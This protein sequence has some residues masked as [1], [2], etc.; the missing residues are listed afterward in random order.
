MT[1]AILEDGK[2]RSVMVLNAYHLMAL[3]QPD[4]EELQPH[5]KQMIYT[6]AHECGHVHDLATKV[7]S[8]PETGLK[9]QL[10]RR[11]GAL[12][13]VAEACWSGYVASR[14]SS[15]LSPRELT[16]DYE[17][18]FCEQA[19]KGLPAVREIPVQ[20]VAFSAVCS[21]EFQSVA[22]RCLNGMEGVIGSIPIR[23]PINPTT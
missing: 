21:V 17:N 6:L 5:Y 23:P 2:A 20:S 14:L 12:F 3:T 11:N 1:P 15:I 7:R 10:S 19:E 16:S 22:L 8:F 18:T 9:V 4:K 13:E